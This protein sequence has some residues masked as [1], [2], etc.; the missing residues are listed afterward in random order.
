MGVNSKLV[1]K[2][3]AKRAGVGLRHPHVPAFLEQRPQTGFLEVHSENYLSAGGP[4][5]RALFDLARD[6]PVSLH[7]V[8]LSLGS[9]AGLDGDHLRRLRGLFA[10]YQPALTSEHL[11]WSV[12]DG[13]YLNDLLPLPL[14]RG[15]S[16]RHRLPQRRPGAQ[17]A[18]G[19]A[20]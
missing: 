19:G 8:G 18:S 11:S 13:I 9:A 2:S 12:D 15:E 7:G 20:S 1:G 17:E 4:R 3:L 14:Q 6:Y 16:A 5:R 10:D